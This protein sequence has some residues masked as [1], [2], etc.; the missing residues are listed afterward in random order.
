MKKMFLFAF[1]MLILS[2]NA[3]ADSTVVCRDFSEDAFGG[4]EVQ[5]LTKSDNSTVARVRFS[6]TTELAQLV[7]TEIKADPYMRDAAQPILGCHEEFL[8]DGGYSLVFTDGDFMGKQYVILSEVSFVGTK[9]IAKLPCR[10]S[11]IP[12]KY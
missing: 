11:T 4:Y 6:D 1:A 5:L 9:E 7:C 2:L 8:N 3:F 10:P 12:P